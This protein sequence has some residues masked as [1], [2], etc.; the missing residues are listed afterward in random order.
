MLIKK[1]Q[2]YVFGLHILKLFFASL[3]LLVTF[4]ALVL[5]LLYAY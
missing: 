2:S 5:T 4:F 1:D 3:K